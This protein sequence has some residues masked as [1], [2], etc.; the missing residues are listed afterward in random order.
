MTTE[1]FT[2]NILNNDWHSEMDG[3]YEAYQELHS[4]TSSGE[5]SRSQTK[6]RED[7]TAIIYKR[8]ERKYGP[9][10][11]PTKGPNPKSEEL[12]RLRC[13]RA[14]YLKNLAN[15][16]AKEK[17]K[18]R[19]RERLEMIYNRIAELTNTNVEEVKKD[20]NENCKGRPRKHAKVILVDD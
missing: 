19:S 1:P 11:R 15:P 18:E 12:K 7:P 16:D 5:Q 10:R 2:E 9:K 17:V 3:V 13:K 6:D 4:C 8:R 14:Y 20:Y